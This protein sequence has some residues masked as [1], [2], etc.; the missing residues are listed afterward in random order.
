MQQQEDFLWNT[1]GIHE[2]VKY[3]CDQCDNQPPSENDLMSHKQT[4]HRGVCYSCDQC[5]HDIKRVGVPEAKSNDNYE[6]REA[7]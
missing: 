1:K 5:M 7:S 6:P 2:V 3:S 4:I